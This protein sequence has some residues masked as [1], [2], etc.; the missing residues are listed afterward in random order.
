MSVQVSQGE[1]NM[2]KT[3][4]NPVTITMAKHICRLCRGK[5]ESSSWSKERPYCHWCW[6][7]ITQIAYGDLYLMLMILSRLEKLEQRK[8]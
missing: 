6:E 5:T 2:M 4:G 1:M 3:T 7:A 8:S